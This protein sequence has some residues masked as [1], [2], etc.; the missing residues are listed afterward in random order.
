MTAPAT[1][2]TEEL[3]MEVLAARYRLGEKI[4]PF[5]S[6]AAIYRAAAVL[7]DRGW[8]TIDAGQTEGTFRA[9]LTQQGI[10]AW[11]LDH[12][13]TPPHLRPAPGQRSCHQ[14][15][16]VGPVYACA[17]CRIGDAAHCILLEDR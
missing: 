4:W 14:H 8:I 2:P 3:F 10:A 6:K 9:S 7:R 16:E 11:H 17:R 12:P 15:P 13:Y 1:T 5:S